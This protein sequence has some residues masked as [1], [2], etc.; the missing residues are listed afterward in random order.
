M[1]SIKLANVITKPEKIL[2]KSKALRN[3]LPT[4][5]SGLLSLGVQRKKF[6]RVQNM[7]EAIK[8]CKSERD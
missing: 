4:C 6:A 8:Y 5:Q 3:Y 7:D 1:L 2:T